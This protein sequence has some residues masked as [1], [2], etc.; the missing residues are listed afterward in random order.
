MHPQF[1]SFGN[2]KGAWWWDIF[3]NLYGSKSI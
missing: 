1:I 2:L 3:R